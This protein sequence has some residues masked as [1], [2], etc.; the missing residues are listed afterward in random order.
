[1]SSVTGTRGLCSHRDSQIM[2]EGDVLPICFVTGAI[3]AV[4]LDSPQPAL[5]ARSP[6][7]GAEEREKVGEERAQ[8]GVSTPTAA[9]AT[10]TLP[11]PKRKPAPSKPGSVC[12]NTSAVP[13]NLPSSSPRP[14]SSSSS[15]PVTSAL[16]PPSTPLEN[17]NTNRNNSTSLNQTPPPFAPSPFSSPLTT[18]SP[19]PSIRFRETPILRRAPRPGSSSSAA[20]SSVKYQTLPTEEGGRSRARRRYS[21]SEGGSKTLSSHQGGGG[22]PKLG[23]IV[24]NKRSQSMSGMLLPKDGDGDS[25]KGRCD[26]GLDLRNWFRQQLETATIKRNFETCSNK[27]KQQPAEEGFSNNAGDGQGVHSTKTGVTRPNCQSGTRKRQRGRPRNLAQI[28]PGQAIPGRAGEVIQDLGAWRTHGRPV[29][30]VVIGSREE[31]KH[32]GSLIGGAEPVGSNKG[33]LIEPQQAFES[34]GGKRHFVTPQRQETQSEENDDKNAVQV[35]TQVVAVLY[36]S[37]LLTHDDN[38]LWTFPYS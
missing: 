14:P 37:S 13:E 33:H 32:Q 36:N 12:S 29:I 21:L 4:K 34:S 30:W 27:Q 22:A 7:G 20:S 31:M 19:V 11:K 2:R 3:P 1:M 9:S 23:R 18:P 17:L 25:D 15:S 5:G 38:E 16:L 6:V 10:G 26:S 35:D 8:A 24:R 28:L